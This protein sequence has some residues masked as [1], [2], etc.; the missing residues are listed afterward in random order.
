MLEMMNR[1]KHT[2]KHKQ[3]VGDEIVRLNSAKGRVW[4]FLRDDLVWKEIGIGVCVC[5]PS[6]LR[7]IFQHASL[8]I[9]RSCSHA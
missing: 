7:T 1:S 3:V 9:W 2:H 6:W 5:V 8:Y 4:L